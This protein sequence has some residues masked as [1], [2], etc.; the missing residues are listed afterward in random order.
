MRRATLIACAFVLLA[1]AVPLTCGIALGQENATPAKLPAF[2]VVSI[3]PSQSGTNWR[4]WWGTTPDGYSVTGQRMF[5]TI[6]L[7]YFPQGTAYWS[8]DRLSGAPALA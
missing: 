7:A 1:I 6:M 4:I 3:R 8:K 2:E 5:T